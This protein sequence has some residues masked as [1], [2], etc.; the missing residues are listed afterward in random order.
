[1]VF[2]PTGRHKVC[3]YDY[4]TNSLTTNKY[5]GENVPRIPGREKIIYR[6]DEYYS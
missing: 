2:S 6:N 1:M 4:L 5:G 3:P